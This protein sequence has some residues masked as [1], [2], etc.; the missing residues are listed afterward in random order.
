MVYGLLLV[1]GLNL[2]PPFAFFL[3]FHIFYNW[4]WDHHKSFWDKAL[5]YIRNNSARNGYSQARSDLELGSIQETQSGTRPNAHFIQSTSHVAIL[6]AGLA[7]LIFVNVL[8]IADIEKTLTDNQGNESTEEDEWGFGQVLALLLLVLPL[9]DAWNAFQDIQEKMLGVQEQFE[10]LFQDKARADSGISMFK[11]LMN[12][13][14]DP[15]KEMRKEDE[16]SGCK[17]FLQ[18]AAYYGKQE[19]VEFLLDIPQMPLNISSKT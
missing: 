18:L 19:L 10:Q 9:R 8:F 5:G 14:A 3:T 13:H 11:E 4:T 1:P 6:L 15:R 16:D 2:I 17:T 7:A 12:R